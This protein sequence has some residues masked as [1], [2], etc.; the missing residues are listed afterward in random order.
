MLGALSVIVDL[1]GLERAA[2]H[3]SALFCDRLIAPA[4]KRRRR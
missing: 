1:L 3:R 4:I 2:R